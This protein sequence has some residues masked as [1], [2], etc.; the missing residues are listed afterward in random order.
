MDKK[1]SEKNLNKI[2]KKEKKEK[3]V[4]NSLNKYYKPLLFFHILFFI[5]INDKIKG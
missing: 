5:F 2:K 4:N 1:D 3:K